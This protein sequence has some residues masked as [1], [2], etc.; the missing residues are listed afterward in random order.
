MTTAGAEGVGG[1][2]IVVG[3]TVPAPP[4]RGASAT[5]AVKSN[6]GASL[7]IQ[8]LNMISGVELARG[9]GVTGRGELAAA[10]LWPTVI[11]LIGVLGLEESVTF[12]VARARDR[13]E[14]GRLLGSALSIASIQSIVFTIIT[15]AAVPIALQ[16]HSSVTITAGLIYSGFIAIN[17]FG[18]AMN[19]MLNGVHR[20]NSYNAARLSIGV[21]VVV[22][23]TALLA[24]GTFSVTVIAATIM[25]CYI[26]CFLFD[27]V[28]TWRARPGRLRSDRATMRRLIGYGVRSAT[29]NTSSFLNQ[30]LDQLVISVFLAA[31]QLGIY[32]V[33]VTFTLFTPLIGASIGVAALPNMA[34]LRTAKEQA[35]LARRL[36]SGAL[37][38]SIVVSLPIIA[39]A[40]VW[41]HLFFGSAFAVGANITRVTAVASISFST[42]RALE[43]VLRGV[44]RPLDA[45]IAEVIALAGTVISLA[46]LLPALGLIGAAYAS[47]LAYTVSGAWMATRIKNRLDIPIRHLLVPD[48]DGLKLAIERLR[49][50]LAARRAGLSSPG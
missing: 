20:Y 30:R 14:V 1:E 45:G 43:G 2:A 7:M 34:R 5:R 31:R 24:T 12:H 37:F 32:V 42:T 11:G 47:L 13:S 50:L 29:S 39:F 15:L 33:A 25:G 10:M 18:V 27:V 36:V 38:A 16:R 6:L 48:R 4:E 44:G 35:L 41:I 22:A 23:Q 26:V 28:L 49:A 8:L 3:P 40:P 21:A 9:L 19:G 46:A 17:T